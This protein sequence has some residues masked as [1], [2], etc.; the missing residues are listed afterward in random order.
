MARLSPARVRL[1]I[2]RRDASCNPER[3]STV[4]ASASPIRP[5]AVAPAVAV[6]SAMPMPRVT[7]VLANN[8]ARSPPGSFETGTA[9][10]VNSDSLASSWPSRR[11]AS[12]AMRSPSCSTSRSPSTTSRPA[13]RTSSP[14][15]RTSARGDERSRKDSSARWV[16]RSW[17][18]VMPITTITAESRKIASAMSPRARYSPPATSSIRNIGSVTTSRTMR[19]NDFG[20][21]PGRL[22]GPS[23][24]RRRTASA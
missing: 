17:T 4:R 1:R 10:P 22:F 8:T 19:K 5:T 18:R 9:S 21:V 14:S 20:S 15:R 12:A 6:T 3:G 7:S 2:R 11:I 16:L 24:A 13:M 23:A